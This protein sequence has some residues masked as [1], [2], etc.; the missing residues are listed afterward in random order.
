MTQLRLK[1]F[2]QHPNHRWVCFRSFILSPLARSTPNWLNL[3]ICELGYKGMDISP[4][5]LMNIERFAKKVISL[6]EY[7]KELAEYLHS[8]MDSIAPNLACLI[9]DVVRLCQTYACMQHF[10]TIMNLI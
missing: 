1:L 5:D 8:K 4:L 9:G 7:R 3:H 6:A 2:T 10:Y